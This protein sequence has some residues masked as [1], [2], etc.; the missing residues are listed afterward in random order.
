MKKKITKLTLSVETLR[1][2][3]EPTL[4]QVAGQATAG[5]KCSIA[6]YIC[7]GCRPCL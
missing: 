5:T 6:T 1:N 3:S 4:Q 7:S 2:L